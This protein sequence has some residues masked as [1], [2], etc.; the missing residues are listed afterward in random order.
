M[1]KVALVAIVVGGTLI[2]CDKGNPFEKINDFDQKPLLDHLGHSIILPAYQKL[3]EENAALET[4]IIAL[5]DEPTSITLA[6]A[7]E[8]LKVA[9][10]AWQWCTPYQFG[11][12]EM[13]GLSAE[14]NIYPVDQNQINQNM[15]SGNYDLSTL[16]NTDA[17]GFPALE[18]LLHDPVLTDGELLASLHGNK[19]TYLTDLV[20]R[21]QTS[22]E[23]V[24]TAWKT[25]GGNYLATFTSEDALG[26]NVGSSVGQ[27]VNAL[28][29]DFERNTRD[30]KIGIP[31]GIRTNGEPVPQNAEAYFAGY[32]MELLH[33]NLKA[34]QHLYLGGEGIGFDDYLQE[35]GAATSGNEELAAKIAG[36]LEAVINA[37]GEIR[38]PLPEAIA[39]EKETVQMLW[40]EMQAL[41]VLFKTDMASSLGVV[42]SYQDN[43]GD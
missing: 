19:R 5:V 6:Q 13:A 38:G 33:E 21:I 39:E 8:Q 1:K 17:R 24:S 9:R 20:E 32:S 7:R 42:I 31:V 2:S 22:S 12:A 28:N 34:Y 25:D 27:L 3:S 11:P 23:S 30:G 40:A 37:A 35:I 15:A 36:Q 26:V 10:L 4:A 14:L 18:F 43:D 41:V 29:L 16:S